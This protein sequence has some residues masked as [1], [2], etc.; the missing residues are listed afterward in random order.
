MASGKIIGTAKKNI[1]IF[2]DWNSTANLSGNYSD[3]TAKLYLYTTG[4]VNS[5]ATKNYTLIVNGQS[6]KGTCVIGNV[7]KGN[8]LL[9]TKTFKVNHNT[10]GSCKCSFSASFDIKIT[11]SGEY[12]GNLSINSQTYDLDKINRS[13]PS[14]T[15]F[16]IDNITKNSFKIHAV[17]SHPYGTQNHYSLNQGAWTS[18]GNEANITGLQPNTDYSV[19]LRATAGNGL[20]AINTKSIKTDIIPVNEITVTNPIS[21]MT[22][23]DEYRLSVEVNSD[24]SIKTVLFSSSDTTVA[25]ISATG[26]ISALKTGETTITIASADG[27]NKQVSFKLTVNSLITEIRT[28]SDTVYIRTGQTQKII[29]EVLPETAKDKSVTFSVPDD[30]G[31]SVSS[32]GVITASNTGNWSITITSA[33]KDTV[34][35]VIECIVLD[36]AVWTDILMPEYLDYFFI[37]AINDNMHYIHENYK[38]I[39]GS[40][41]LPEVPI[42]HG[43]AT[44]LSDVLNI[45]NTIESNIDFLNENSLIGYNPYYKDKHSYNKD[46]IVSSADI[47]RWI[48]FIQFAYM[49]SNNLI[50]K[51]KILYD[52][53]TFRLFDKNGRELLIGVDNNVTE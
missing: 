26:V 2:I 29:Y 25:V 12:I 6:H 22:E 21:E 36:K 4:T 3:V 48:D 39:Y 37:K 40:D 9:C 8:H 17:S 23:N 34:N 31:I 47:K 49:R 20:T 24:A 51:I 44:P 18:M 53:N 19:R 10:D 14:I 46:S 41:E 45:L 15:S 50:E 5:T 42:E 27:R 11:Y 43:Y 1:Y 28:M 38:V 35:H 32:D 16:Y 33:A 52:N 30:A 13:A 7:S